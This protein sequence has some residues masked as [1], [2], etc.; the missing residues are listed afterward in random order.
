MKTILIAI[1]FSDGA[2]HAANY[3]YLLAQQIKADIILCNAVAI[4]AEM[5]Q[6]GLSVWPKDIYESLLQASIDDTD[7]LKSDLEN[8]S[9]VSDF[10]PLIS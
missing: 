4:P 8:F 1:D 5:P 2:T 7:Q 6:A 3:G 10:R 9:V